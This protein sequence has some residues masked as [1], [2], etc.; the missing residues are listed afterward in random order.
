[1]EST[2]SSPDAMVEASRKV[3]RKERAIFI[4]PS[5]GWLPRAS[6]C[7]RRADSMTAAETRP[8]GVEAATRPLSNVQGFS[9]SEM[10]ERVPAAQI[11]LS[12]SVLG[13]RR[14]NDLG[15]RSSDVGNRRPDFVLS[16]LRTQ[17]LPFGISA[18]AV[19]AVVVGCW[20]HQP[21]DLVTK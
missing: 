19:D 12:L 5:G 2:T 16:S 6:R 10:T 11:V 18:E 7:R 1:V 4:Y 21:V 8:S 3:K 13:I 14:G 9:A 17:V 15:F 20:A